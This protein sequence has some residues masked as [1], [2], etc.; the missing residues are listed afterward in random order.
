MQL[1]GGLEHGG[2]TYNIE[3]VDWEYAAKDELDVEP[4]Y[5]NEEALESDL[6]EGLNAEDYI[7]EG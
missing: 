3:D 2:A 5:E 7:E 1:G 4:S 6:P